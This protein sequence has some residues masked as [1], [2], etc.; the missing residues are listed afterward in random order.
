VKPEAQR[1]LVM[2]YRF[3]GDT[4]LT[5]PFLR[6]LR[7]AYPQAQIDVLVGPQSGAVLEGCPYINEI[8]TFDTTNFHKYDRGTGKKRNFFSYALDLR[9][10][11][12]DL[13]FVLKR[14]L[15]SGVLAWLTGART[16]IGY[17]TQGRGFLLTHRVPWRS[18]IHEVESTL[19]VLTAAGIDI[20]DDYLECWISPADRKTVFDL[21]PVT[22]TTKQKVLFHAASAHPDKMYPIS[23]WAKVLQGM[24]NQFDIEAFFTGSESDYDLYEQL[25]KESG[26]SGHNLAGK[27][28]IRESMALIGRMNMAICVDSGPAHLAA[29]AGVPVVAIFGPTDPARWG[30]W[31]ENHRVIVKSSLP[32]RPCNYK[33]TCD[34]RRECLTELE[35][36]RIVE[37]GCTILAGADSFGMPV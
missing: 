5:V 23:S 10:R 37:A 19:D 18:D 4:I 27:L 16:R 14:S 25:Q 33:K 9:K 30:P 31:G 8:I 29:A 7:R 24:S 3:I 28:S 21:A 2:R 11:K 20:E 35:P 26:I 6:N 1:I 15:S 17:D 13:V 32:C 22:K 34:D 12:Y 36:E